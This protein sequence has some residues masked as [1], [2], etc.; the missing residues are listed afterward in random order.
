M[1]ALADLGH[2]AATAF[3]WPV[4]VWTA[5]A[6]ACLGL[7]AVVRRR[8][9]LLQMDARIALLVALPLTLI[10]APHL[11]GPRT[12]VSP[13]W[14]QIAETT[15]VAG[16]QSS[17]SAAS[18]VATEPDTDWAGR[19]LGLWTMIAAALSMIGLGRLAAGARGLH[20]LLEDASIDIASSRTHG[21]EVLI[22]QSVRAPLAVGVLKKRVILPP[23]L[24]HT[25]LAILHELE[26]HRAGDLTRAWLVAG[27]RAAFW[28]HPL[29]HILARSIPRW[30]EM[31]CDQRLLRAGLVRRADYAR[32]LLQTAAPSAALPGTVG[33]A[34]PASLTRRLQA[35]AETPQSLN[36]LSLKALVLVP[37]VAVA[38][39]CLAAPERS[40]IPDLER[41]LAM[42]VS[43]STEAYLNT[44]EV[45]EIP[46][47]IAALS[48]RLR[49]PT[50]E[51]PEQ[52]QGR[53]V[54]SFQLDPEGRVHEPHIER[55]MTDECDREAI[56]VLTESQFL[57]G[58]VSG[59][60]VWTR[61][62]LPVTFRTDLTRRREPGERIPTRDLRGVPDRLQPDRPVPIFR[63]AEEVTR[64]YI[65]VWTSSPPDTSHRF[66][67][68]LARAQE[69]DALVVGTPG[70]PPD[71]PVFDGN[72]GFVAGI[73][74]TD[75]LA[76]RYLQVELLPEP[77]SLLLEYAPIAGAQ[78]RR[79]R[80]LLPL[81]VA[82]TINGKGA[83]EEG[84]S[85]RGVTTI[86]GTD[87]TF[88]AR[89]RGHLL[90]DIRGAAE[91]V[92]TRFDSD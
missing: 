20:Q 58:I 5:L 92:M 68:G 45:P 65:L 64:P 26:H 82:L 63:F 27:L 48:E 37:A 2:A 87:M 56:R 55:G 46:G 25:E 36:R 29:V 28:F 70:N 84:G 14:T 66:L 60:R 32:A 52:F 18:P 69:T 62:A 40:S 81:D 39:G 72:R 33:M 3:W 83:A 91:V 79:L 41:R 57:P 73:Q 35:L 85:E 75:H 7:L 10:L 61:F 88:A 76:D 78:N 31:L 13:V 15:V 50:P 30:A 1:N 24:R 22:S 19:L 9:W 89:W 12:S 38:G 90:A 21:L 71:I 53:V 16:N 47:G 17:S 74:F 80:V 59:E 8:D 44:D 54:V 43:A 4:F 51:C 34:D 23:G 67:A 11:P 6:T 49:Y 86:R 77:D 42:P